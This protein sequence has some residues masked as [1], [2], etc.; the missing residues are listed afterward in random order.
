M[1]QSQVLH[2]DADGRDNA[3]SNPSLLPGVTPSPHA[4]ELEIDSEVRIMEHPVL[5]GTRVNID[6]AQIMPPIIHTGV[7]YRF[8]YLCLD[9]DCLY[10]LF[11]S[12]FRNLWDEKPK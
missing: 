8:R 3:A 9:C 7:N 10:S 6:A 5:E 11:F 12:G 4:S 1:E 2:S